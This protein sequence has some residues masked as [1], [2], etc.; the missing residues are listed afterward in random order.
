V[1]KRQTKK[2][3]TWKVTCDHYTQQK[4]TRTTFALDV[5]VLRQ[6]LNIPDVSLKHLTTLTADQA[7]AFV[8]KNYGVLQVQGPRLQLLEVGKNKHLLAL[9]KLRCQMDD[10]LAEF[11]EMK[12]RF[13]LKK[14]GFNE[15]YSLQ[16]GLGVPVGRMNEL[17]AEQIA[18]AVGGI[19]KRHLR[20]HAISIVKV[21][22]TH[23]RKPDL[24]RDVL[25]KLDPRA[26]GT[27]VIEAF[28]EHST[29]RSDL[30]D[31]LRQRHQGRISS[32]SAYSEKR[33]K[34]AMYA[35][36]RSLRFIDDNASGMYDIPK[37]SKGQPVRWFMNNADADMT[38][39]MLLAFGRD[40]K[41]QN[42]RVRSEESAHQSIPLVSNMLYMLKKGVADTFASVNSIQHFT[43]DRIV[44][45]IPNL[46]VIADKSVRRTF[47][48]AEVT[49]M[50][51]EIEDDSRFMLILTILREIGLRNGA[52]SYMRYSCLVDANHIPRHTCRVSEKGNVIREFLTSS[53]LKTRIAAYVHTLR[54]EFDDIDADEFYMFGHRDHSSPCT[55]L[56][57]SLETIAARAKVT[58]NVHPHA[59]RHTIVGKL[60]DAGNSIEIVSKFMGHKKVD[61]TMRHYWIQSAEAIS[62]NIKNPFMATYHNAEEKKDAM[63]EALELSQRKVETA[64]RIIQVYNTELATFCGETPAALELKDRIFEKIPNLAGLLSMMAE[65]LDGDES[66]CS[67]MSQLSS[68]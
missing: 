53:N 16:E 40:V 5:R 61:T 58:I 52:I 4:V 28:Q 21:V 30:M 39:Q 41:I 31:K 67:S 36:C 9:E 48:D 11:A 56:L 32:S 1:E 45:Q 43:V 44:G 3:K 57:K 26:G 66:V 10:A 27:S 34:S 54:A 12:K 64:L 23:T 25:I 42:D 68:L 15:Y 2:G 22:L 24:L 55:T 65:S 33:L 29:W 38:E 13:T 18:T 35:D 63:D 19:K 20:R 37:T 60:I 47:T 59:F 8:V 17:T 14:C 50:F 49:A 51:K 6:I 46:R 7:R 62:K